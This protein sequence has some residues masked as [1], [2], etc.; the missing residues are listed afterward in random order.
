MV[1]ATDGNWYAYFANVE[2][3]KVADSTVGKAGEGLDFG[4]FC[5]RLSVVGDGT[6]TGTG[7]FTDSDGF[8][9]ARS[10][11]ADTCDDIVAPAGV[12]QNNVVRKAKTPSNPTG[13]PND[14]GQIGILLD[15]WP[16]IQLYSFDDVTI[17][18]NPGGPA[19]QF[20]L[21]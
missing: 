16:V 13:D 15:A 14:R 21:E 17:Q 5:P 20:S 19:Q 4:S 11:T 18:Y 2:K 8:Y 12:F 3:A 9:I 7:L 10:S 1:Q 6:L